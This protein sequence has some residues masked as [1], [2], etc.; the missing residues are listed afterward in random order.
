MAKVTATG[1]GDPRIVSDHVAACREHI[2][3][4]ASDL[5]GGSP[6][7]RDQAA[8]HLADFGALRD[9]ITGLLEKHSSREKRAKAGS[10]ESTTSVGRVGRISVAAGPV[11]L[12]LL[13]PPRARGV[14]GPRSI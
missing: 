11:L 6:D 8:R 3:H 5:E 14:D 4:I 7:A 2:K 13:H 1:P 10:P 12:L 9:E